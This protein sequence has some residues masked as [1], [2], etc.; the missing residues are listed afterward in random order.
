[1]EQTADLAAVLAFVI[2]RIE[3]QAMLSGKPLNEE[4]RF[5]LNNLLRF[6]QRQR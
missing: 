2:G 4:E 5:L 6:P 3:E 1:M